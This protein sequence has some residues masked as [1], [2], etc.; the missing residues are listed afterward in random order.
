[1]RLRLQRVNGTRYVSRAPAPGT[2]EA[3]LRARPGRPVLGV[4]WTLGEGEGAFRGIAEPGDASIF[5]THW[6][7]VGNFLDNAHWLRLTLFPEMNKRLLRTDIKV[8]IG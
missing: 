1:M 3:A 7:L 6:K 8:P 5:F 2:S 4:V